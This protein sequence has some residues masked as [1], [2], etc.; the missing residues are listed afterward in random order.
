MGDF[1]VGGVELWEASTPCGRE[2]GLSG[3][4]EFQVDTRF[5]GQVVQVGIKIRVGVKEAAPWVVHFFQSSTAAG[6][7]TDQV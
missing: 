6:A 3:H 4:A 1:S 5:I 2:V 7:E